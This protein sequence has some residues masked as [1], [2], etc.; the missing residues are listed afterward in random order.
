VSR[1]SEASV[2]IAEFL[3][4]TATTT[5]AEAEISPPCT[6]QNDDKIESDV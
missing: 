6:I 5:T 1:E 2:V 3:H 4:K